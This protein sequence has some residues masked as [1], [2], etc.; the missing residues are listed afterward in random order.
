MT[1]FVIL[2]CAGMIITRFNTVS[3][4]A[5]KCN[6]LGLA[7]INLFPYYQKFKEIIPRTGFYDFRCPTSGRPGCV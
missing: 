5:T 6:P 4:N 2:M 3:I 1:E 7:P